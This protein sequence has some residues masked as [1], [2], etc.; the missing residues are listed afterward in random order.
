MASPLFVPLWL[1]SVI[2]FDAWHCAAVQQLGILRTPTEYGG[3]SKSYRAEH[4]ACYMTVLAMLYALAAGRLFIL[5]SFVV[6]RA[7]T[8]HHWFL[9]VTRICRMKKKTRVFELELCISAY[10]CIVQPWSHVHITGSIW[11]S[12]CGDLYL[13][14]A[15]NVSNHVPAHS[16]F[17]LRV[18]FFGTRTNQYRNTAATTL[19]PIYANSSPIL[20]QRSE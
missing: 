6:H 9:Q 17:A 10:L 16:V 20:R 15:A 5:S 18:R 1:V 14:Q 13:Q 7:E 12:Q 19:N 8:P 3:W 2:I 11:E 4:R